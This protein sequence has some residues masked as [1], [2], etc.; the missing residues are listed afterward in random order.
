M[1]WREAQ[2]LAR[3]VREKVFIDGGE[4]CR[5]SSSGTNGTMPATTQAG[6]DARGQTIARR[7]CRPTGDR[8][9]GGA[10]GL[11]PKGVGAALLRAMLDRA[12]SRSMARAFLHAQVQAAA[13][14]RRFVSG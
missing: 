4:G 14:Y 5:A 1:A 7:P 12:R 9:H 8:A 10:Q 6:L 3:P 11:A 2:A 13:F